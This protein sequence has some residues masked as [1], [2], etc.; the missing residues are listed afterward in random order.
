MDNL[1]IPD[2]CLNCNSRCTENFSFLSGVNEEQQYNIMMS[3]DHRIWKKNS[4]LFHEG[5]PV[6]AVYIIHKGRVKLSTWDAEGREQIVGIF[7]DNDAIWEGIFLP[8]SKFPYSGICLTETDCCK[9]TRERLEKVMR[10]PGIALQVI[11]L[12]SQK[13]HDAN[14]RVLLLST[15]S[16]KARVAGFLLQRCQHTGSD[17]VTLRLEDIASS[18]SVRTETVSRKIKELE[19]DGLIKKVGQSSV[20]ILNS[21]ALEAAFRNERNPI[22]NCEK[23]VEKS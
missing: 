22:L 18:L 12:L 7:A 5:D 9:L 15:N 8:G 4:Y 20:R 11:G 10:D 14:N 19:K 2:K 1:R 23:K 13:L 3:S 17:T 21:E 6:D 16:P